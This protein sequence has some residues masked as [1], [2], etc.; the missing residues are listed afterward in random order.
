MHSNPNTEILSRTPRKSESI[1]CL[2]TGPVSNQI[3]TVLDDKT[4]AEYPCPAKPG[5]IAETGLEQ[6]LINDLILKNVIHIGEFSHQTA[7]AYC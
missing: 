4:S 3:P 2:T 7:F 5:T 1:S 6:T